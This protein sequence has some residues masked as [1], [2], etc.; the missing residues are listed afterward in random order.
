MRIIHTLKICLK[1]QFKYVNSCIHIT[2]TDLHNEFQAF[3]QDYMITIIIIII[4]NVVSWIEFNKTRLQF[5]SIQTNLSAFNDTNLIPF[6]HFW[7][8]IGYKD[9]RQQTTQDQRPAN[10]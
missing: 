9:C 4:S 5:P 6:M 2:Y 1:L 8:C 3:Q 10:S 7:I